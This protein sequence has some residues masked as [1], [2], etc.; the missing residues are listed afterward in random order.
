MKRRLCK[1]VASATIL[2]FLLTGCYRE[3][4]ETP[5]NFQ[6]NT[7]RE[8]VEAAE[9]AA[10][11]DAEAWSPPEWLDGYTTGLQL[12]EAG[13]FEGAVES[14]TRTL[15][16]AK[17]FELGYINRGIAYR[18]LREY[19]KA[20]S[21]F[22]KTENNH[23]LNG[24]TAPT[25]LAELL[26]ACPDE[27]F[28]NGKEAVS[29]AQKACE[30]T[31]WEHGAVIA[32]L[33]AAHAEGGDF[34]EA[35]KWQTVAEERLQ[36][37]INEVS[38]EELDDEDKAELR[39]IKQGLYQAIKGRLELYREGKPCRE[40]LPDTFEIIEQARAKATGE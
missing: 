31:N 20:I 29:I 13:D 16:Q 27:S 30:R 4:A 1:R 36:A 5:M 26:A 32:I 14:I 25:Y 38:N 15:D 40:L 2:A 3:P 39:S 11:A 17:D 21:D 7:T 24:Y 34:E 8:A 10:A 23:V 18:H 12:M 37:E 19:G 22:R 9:Q 6:I 33:A 35:V 28:R